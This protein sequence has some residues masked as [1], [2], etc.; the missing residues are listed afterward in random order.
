MTS[1][2][3]FAVA[4]EESRRVDN[5][6]HELDLAQPPLPLKYPLRRLALQPRDDGYI[7]GGASGVGGITA[8]YGFTFT[9]TVQCCIFLHLG[10]AK[11]GH[12]QRGMEGAAI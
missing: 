6:T 8:D 10:A 4:D 5:P 2:P 9:F 3:V 12:T 11:E 1:P 7:V